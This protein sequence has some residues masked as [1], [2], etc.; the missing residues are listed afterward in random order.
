MIPLTVEEVFKE[1]EKHYQRRPLSLLAARA[2]P[3]RASVLAISSATLTISARAREDCGIPK[4]KS[5]NSDSGA[6]AGP[7]CVS[8]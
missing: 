3:R 7:R 1:L 6:H 2:I 5:G 4:A 8:K